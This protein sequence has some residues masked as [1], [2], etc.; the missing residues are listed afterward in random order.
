MKL[1]KKTLKM[2]FITLLSLILLVVAVGFIFMQT[3]KQFGKAPSKEQKASFELLDHY[4]DGSFQNYDN[5]QMHMGFTDMFKMLPEYFKSGTAREPKASLPQEKMDSIAVAHTPDSAIQ[6]N[7]FG[8]S[9]LLLHMHGKRIMIDPM[10]GSTPAPHPLLGKSRYEPGLP[11]TAE[12]LPELD[13]VL[14][15]H[16]HYDHLDYESV[17]KI[18]DKTALF[19]VPLGLKNHLVYWGVDSNKVQ[20]FDWWQETEIDGYQFVC[21]PAQHFSGRGLGDRGATLWCSWVVMH[22]GKRIYFSGDSGYG[23]HFKEIGNKYGPFDF[24]MMECGQYNERWTE[25]HM[26]PE[27]TAKAAQDVQAKSFMPIHWGAF[28]L[29]MHDWNDSPK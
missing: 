12:Q 10:L 8:H 3:S 4:A 2:I 7:W 24:A 6:L 18:K 19:L 28:T 5:I 29:A 15:S 27:E 17:I 20:E 9:T 26:M 25:I 14:F 13:I 11:M 22:E 23:R 21:T 16:D 1:L